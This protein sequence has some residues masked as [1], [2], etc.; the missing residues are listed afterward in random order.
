MHPI[1]HLAENILR[2]N[3]MTPPY[4]YKLTYAVTYRC[5]S[6][7][8][9]CYVW[10]KEAQPEMSLDEI[11]LFFKRSPEFTWVDLTGGEI[12]LRKDIVGIAEIIIRNCPGLY[13]LH[14]P[15]NGLLPD[16]ITR[17][18]KEIL[19]LIPHRLIV[20]LSIDGPREL[21]DQIRG[22]KGFFDKTIETIRRL[23]EMSS[24]RFQVFPGMTLSAMNL[25][26]IDNTVKALQ[27]KIPGF[28]ASELHVNIA[29]VSEHF[30][31][32]S[33]MDISFQK[34]ALDEIRAF[35]KKKGRGSGGVQ[36]IERVYLKL[37]EKYIRTG[38]TPLPCQ[39]LS[40]S[41]FI[42]P[43]GNIY[44]CIADD[45]IVGSLKDF[46]YS[47]RKA[48]ST[49]RFQEIRGRIRKGFCHHCWTPCEA[50]QTIYSKLGTMGWYSVM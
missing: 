45:E 4:P 18:V 3:V 5:N 38:K 42:D 10:K 11:E 12:F 21:H 31:G 16:R 47:L 33:G 36:A 46:D 19:D 39:A 41:C 40:S 8:R 14:F 9:T 24:N 32:N 27:K 43:E 6:R 29:Q 25:G 15:T 44:P 2:A 37:A 35:A 13:L 7:C 20:S 28:Q 1:F 23:R 26:Q 49:T 17:G 22:G 30:Y 48:W 34:A 50:Y